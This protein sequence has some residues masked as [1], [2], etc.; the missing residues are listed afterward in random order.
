MPHPS[1]FRFQTETEIETEGE[2]R[3]GNPGLPVGHRKTPS[4][5]LRRPVA[6]KFLRWGIGGRLRLLG[7]CRVVCAGNTLETDGT[8][9]FRGF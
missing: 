5:S 7:G 2:F 3:C 9:S 6:K 4:I 8:V 1:G